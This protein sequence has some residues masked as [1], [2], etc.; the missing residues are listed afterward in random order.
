VSDEPGGSHPDFLIQLTKLHLEPLPPV[1]AP[2]APEAAPPPTA[3]PVPAAPIMAEPVA[4]AVPVEAP[5]PAAIPLLQ[6]H[7][8]SLALMIA[9]IGSGVAFCV[10]L[11]GGILGLAMGAAVRGMFPGVF[12]GLVV[13][14]AAWILALSDLAKMEQGQMHPAGRLLA[15]RGRFAAMITCGAWGFVLYTLLVFQIGF[16]MGKASG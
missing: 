14:A 15:M 4:V 2:A 10:F 11:M 8:G 6:D 13:G 5:P 7:H 1:A 16:L 12:L 3:E 9:G